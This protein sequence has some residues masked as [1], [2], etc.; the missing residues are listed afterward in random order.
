M[1]IGEFN[2]KYYNFA[3]FIDR[4]IMKLTRNTTAF[5]LWQFT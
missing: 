4:G 3:L 5:S 2:L 1:L